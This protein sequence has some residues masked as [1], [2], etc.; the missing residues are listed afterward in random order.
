[1]RKFSPKQS[2]VTVILVVLLIWVGFGL[3]VYYFLASDIKKI[4]Q[5]FAE[6]KLDLA[7]LD[8]NARNLDYFI[9][10]YDKVKDDIAPLEA[11]IFGK[12]ETIVFIEKLEKIAVDYSISQSIDLGTQTEEESP[13]GQKQEEKP[14]QSKSSAYEILDFRLELRGSFPNVVKYLQALESLNNYVN[15][16][17]ISLN[18][19]EENEILAVVKAEVCVK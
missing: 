15:I 3:A 7:Q 1:M 10:D 17:S 13:K 11:V 16:N 5:E 9:S 4:N 14:A 19:K 6:K 8:Y 12:E 18:L 2:L